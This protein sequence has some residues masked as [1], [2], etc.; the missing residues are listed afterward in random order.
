MLNDEFVTVNCHMNNFAI[1]KSKKKN[2]K[3]NKTY[4]SR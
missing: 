1:S 2:G 4:F 3:Q